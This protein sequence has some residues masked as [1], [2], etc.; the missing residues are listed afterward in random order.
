MDSSQIHLLTNLS[1]CWKTTQTGKSGMLQ[2]CF[3]CNHKFITNITNKR[4][5]EC[6]MQL[7]LE[8]AITMYIAALSSVSDDS[9][10]LLEKYL[11]KS[12]FLS[13]LCL[14]AGNIPTKISLISTTSHFH[15]TESFCQE[16]SCLIL[17]C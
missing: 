17:R 13:R 4:R 3:E 1:T 8:T 5:L 6:K 14:K 11:A 9:R 16:A 7:T 12:Y 2:N 10:K 15:I